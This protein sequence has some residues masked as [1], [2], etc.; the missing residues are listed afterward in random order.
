VFFS[1][2]FTT[3]F[4]VLL[5]VHP[6]IISQINTTRCTILLNIFIYLLCMFLVCRL[7]SIQP[8]DQK[9]LIQSDKYQCR[10]DTAIFS[11]WWAHGYPKHVEKR[12]KYIKQ[13]YGPNWT[14]FQDCYVM[15][16]ERSRWFDV[17]MTLNITTV[18]VEC[19]FV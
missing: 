13:N 11:W 2:I 10:I 16:L 15:F 12:N 3:F 4:Y 18:L 8:A 5:T 17:I 1:N 14:Y 6:C 9:P 19:D 7:N